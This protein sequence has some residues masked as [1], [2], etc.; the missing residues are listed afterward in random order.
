ML[1]P[2]Q[3]QQLLHKKEKTSQITNLHNRIFT[4][5]LLFA[6][7]SLPTIYLLSPSI[8][9]YIL[10]TISS[11]SSGHEFLSIFLCIG[12][13]NTIKCQ[14][15]AHAPTDKDR[16]DALNKCNWKLPFVCLIFGMAICRMI[17]KIRNSTFSEDD[18]TS[19][20]W[21]TNKWWGIRFFIAGVSLSCIALTRF[22][23]PF[24]IGKLLYKL[25]VV[26]VCISYK[27]LISSHVFYFYHMQS[28]APIQYHI[29]IHVKYQ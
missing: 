24:K 17:G 25:F 26:Y 10:S 1:R 13:T 5:R 12:L 29:K 21:T 18:V 20:W 23:G 11:L 14:I 4:P 3:R 16:I 15:Y 2:I 28:N 8:I 22:I 6:T 27:I 9:L 19:P 7:L